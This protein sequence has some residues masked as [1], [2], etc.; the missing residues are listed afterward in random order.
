ML[1]RRWVV[2]SLLVAA[3]GGA[4]A[5]DKAGSNAD[6]ANFLDGRRFV[7]RLDADITGDGV[8]DVI[9]VSADDKRITSTVTVLLRLH[10]KTVDGKGK[11]EGLQGV[12]S[13]EVELSPLG[14]PTVTIKNG[15][16]IVEHLSGGS[17][18]RTAA[19]YR[20]R[21]DAEEGRMRLIG[22]DAKRDSSNLSVQLSWNVLNGARIT[23]RG[24]N[25]SKSKVRPETL[26]MSMTPNVEELLD[27]VK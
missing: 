6:I 24:K 7:S 25:E 2:A 22:L 14:T 10:G 3:C 20:Y 15:V 12:D 13:L 19:T 21:F 5:A 23:K 18:V 4:Q 16:L 26:Y 17:N 27:K 8:A 11:M 1:I 9:F